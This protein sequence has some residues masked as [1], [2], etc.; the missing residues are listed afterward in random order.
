[1]NDYKPQ[2]EFRDRLIESDTVSPKLEERRPASKSKK[3][4][5]KDDIILLFEQGNTVEQVEQ[6]TGL[7]GRVIGGYKGYLK[8][9][10]YSGPPVRVDNGNGKGKGPQGKGPQGKEGGVTSSEPKADPI[11]PAPTP[12]DGPQVLLEAG[13]GEAQALA[14]LL[15]KPYLIQ[16]RNVYVSPAALACYQFLV[17]KGWKGSVGD[18]FEMCVL[19]CFKELYGLIPG[20]LRPEVP[21][22]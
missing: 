9:P 18:F 16:V 14:I 21:A 15:G 8:S 19:K 7:S 10:I 6:I 12:A 5:A 4:W 1:L 22:S 2:R 11:A 13:P 3:K 20:M 17:A